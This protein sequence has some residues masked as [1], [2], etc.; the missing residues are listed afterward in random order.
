MP[1]NPVSELFASRDINDKRIVKERECPC[2]IAIGAFENFVLNV[3]SLGDLALLNGN[4]SLYSF[5]IFLRAADSVL[6]R[7]IFIDNERNIETILEPVL[8]SL[9]DTMPFAKSV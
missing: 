4:A 6:D 5:A 9:N 1:S 3:S 7:T 8:S 2:R